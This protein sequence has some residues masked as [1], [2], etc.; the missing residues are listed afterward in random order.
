LKRNLL[1]PSNFVA[2]QRGMVLIL[3]LIMLVAMTLAGIALYRQMGTGVVIA[4]NL[5]FKRAATVAADAGI[6]AARAW[7]IS[8]GDT[9]PERLLSSQSA[10]GNFFY[11]P[12]WCYGP[13]SV[14]S[15]AATNPVDC[16]A[17]TS[18]DFVPANY[19]W[20]NAAVISDAAGNEIRYVIHRLCALPGS[21]N[22]ASQPGQR[23]ASIATNPGGTAQDQGP[24]LSVVAFPYYRVTA[25]VRDSLG[26]TR[27][28]TQ[29]IM[30]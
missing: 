1:F 4:R 23:C 3:A 13:A 21:M 16:S 14:A 29:V 6:E 9:N 8:T 20:D 15:E 2:R 5:T 26:S 25:R 7:L 19:N 30:Y 28:Y 18:S 11:Y 27:A 24:H 12:A 10:S 22:I 17:S